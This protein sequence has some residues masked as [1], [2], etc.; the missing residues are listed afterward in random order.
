MRGILLILIREVYKLLLR[1][2]AM[3]V[4]DYVVCALCT[5][6]TCTFNI[7]FST[8]LSVHIIELL[9]VIQYHDICT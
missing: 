6:H 7:I 8:C 4:I 5:L 9:Y 2:Q 3:V 1:Y